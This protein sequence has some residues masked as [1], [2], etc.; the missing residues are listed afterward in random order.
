MLEGRIDQILKIDLTS[1]H[2]LRHAHAYTRTILFHVSEKRMQ[3]AVKEG[4]QGNRPH[5]ITHGEKTCTDLFRFQSGSVESGSLSSSVTC[6]LCSLP[7]NSGVDPAPLSTVAP[8]PHSAQQEDT[9]HKPPP[10]VP[11]ENSMAPAN[12]RAANSPTL[13]PAAATQFSMTCRDRA[14]HE[15]EYSGRAWSWD[16]HP[17]MGRAVKRHP[18]PI[19]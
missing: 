3:K 4:S 11:S 10:C 17:G 5:E 15:A 12:T 1:S 6:G 16:V 2:T 13:N 18:E 8:C 14:Q 7:Y 9:L 19:L